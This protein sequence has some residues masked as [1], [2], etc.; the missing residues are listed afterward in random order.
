MVLVVLS[1][2]GSGEEWRGVE[3]SGKEW[4]G[5]VRGPDPVRSWHCLT[6]VRSGVVLSGWT[7]LFV[8]V[9]GVGLGVVVSKVLL[10]LLV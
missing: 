4:R 5:V 3:R 10:V 2:S 7:H 1:L 8:V 6:V 9:V